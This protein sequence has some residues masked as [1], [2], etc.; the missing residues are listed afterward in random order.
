MDKGFGRCSGKMQPHRNGPT[1][2][3]SQRIERMAK[4]M[5]GMMVQLLTWECEKHERRRDDNERPTPLEK[6]E[7]HALSSGESEP[8]VALREALTIVLNL[9]LS[10]SSYTESLSCDVVVA[11]LIALPTRPRRD[12]LKLCVI[13]SLQTTATSSIFCAGIEL[14]TPLLS[15]SVITL[16]C[17]ERSV[18]SFTSDDILRVRWSV[19]RCFQAFLLVGPSYR[20]TTSLVHRDL[21]AILS[22]DSHLCNVL[23]I[24]FFVTRHCVGVRPRH[25][26][27]Q[28]H[29]LSSRGPSSMCFCLRVR[30]PHFAVGT[31]LAWVHHP[32]SVE[33]RVAPT[34]NCGPVVDVFAVAQTDFACAH[35]LCRRPS[36]PRYCPFCRLL[37]LV[38]LVLVVVSV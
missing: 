29:G 12:G 17:D 22:L 8:Y 19:D 27:H 32:P 36:S 30:F 9:L 4:Y 10:C 18:S 28:Q 33:A 5:N 26:H 37:L 35:R 6:L 1:R 34:V 15:A 14:L 3:D 31:T 23:A 25:P 13:M 11:L 20:H 7:F 21:L 2:N 24:S 38:P 16:E